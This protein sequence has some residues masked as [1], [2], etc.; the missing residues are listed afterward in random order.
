MDLL[1]YLDGS[2][3]RLVLAVALS[4]LPRGDLAA[5]NFCVDAIAALHSDDPLPESKAAFD[6]LMQKS[7]EVQA[8]FFNDLYFWSSGQLGKISYDS[9]M[10]SVSNQVYKNRADKPFSLGNNAVLF[11]D[12]IYYEGFIRRLNQ[13]GNLNTETIQNHPSMYWKAS[14]SKW[15]Y[16]DTTGLKRLRDRALEQGRLFRGT[17]KVEADLLRMVKAVLDGKTLDHAQVKQVL[18]PIRDGW[19]LNTRN[20]T[21]ISSIIND[22]EKVSENSR[23]D[24]RDFAKKLISLVHDSAPGRDKGYQAIHTSRSD[25]VAK[26][27]ARGEVLT[28][29]F[30]PEIMPAKIRN[31]LG[32]G[33]EVAG[34][35]KHP[36][37]EVVFF[38]PDAMIYLI[39]HLK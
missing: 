31:S 27:W 15:I 6:E 22:A 21:W 37:I 38:E 28:F 4:L 13:A 3:L 24:K 35:G 39:E 17:N 20:K 14:E 18:I 1:R 33:I 10:K 30:D 8:R 2:S 32:A 12:R 7:F 29:E 26:K 23:G 19:E 36:D 5:G 11:E 34:A 16:D 9:S 25:K